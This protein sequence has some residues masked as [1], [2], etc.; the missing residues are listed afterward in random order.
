MSSE[1]TIVGTMHQMQYL[2]FFSIFVLA[3][4]ARYQSQGLPD[5]D[6]AVLYV[7]TMHSFSGPQLC[8]RHLRPWLWV[9]KANKPRTFSIVSQECEQTTFKV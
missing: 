4:S 2:G 5:R 3:G 1:H 7:P 9:G 6:T 8:I